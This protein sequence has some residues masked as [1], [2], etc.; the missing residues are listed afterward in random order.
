[1]GTILEAKN[2]AL[3]AHKAA[4]TDSRSKAIYDRWLSDTLL[5]VKDSPEL[6][7]TMFTR[8]AIAFEIQCDMRGWHDGRVAGVTA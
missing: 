8:L 6:A 2:R 1:M 7:E 5:A 4:R 3:R